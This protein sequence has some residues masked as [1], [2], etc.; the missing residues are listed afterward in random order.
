MINNTL[1]TSKCNYSIVELK[2]TISKKIKYIGLVND[3]TRKM[4]YWEKD[5]LVK[6]SISKKKFNIATSKNFPKKLKKSPQ[7]KVLT[8]LIIIA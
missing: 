6:I 4:Y 1:K 7:D 8:T 3:N 2:L 5:T